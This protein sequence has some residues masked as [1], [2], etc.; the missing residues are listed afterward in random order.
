[1]IKHSNYNELHDT[2]TN[3][4]KYNKDV[5]NNDYNLYRPE[6]VMEIFKEVLDNLLST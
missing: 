3:W 2:L 1:M 5:S 6:K 4:N